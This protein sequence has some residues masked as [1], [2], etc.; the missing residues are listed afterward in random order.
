[1][2]LPDVLRATWFCV[3]LFTGPTAAQTNTGEI[4]GTI[5][6]ES[7]GVLPGATVVV[8]HPSSGF[9]VERVSDANGRFFI[10]SLP[11][12]EWEVEVELAGF[13]RAIQ[14]GVVLQIGRTLDLVFDLALG[15]LSEEVT[16][17]ASA[18]TLQTTTAE[19][20]DEIGRAHV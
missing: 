3:F 8:T 1:M 6:D 19:I 15:Q 11:I 14:R 20:S 5:R 4:G 16:V 18:P 13:S 10:S 17:A 9:S 12:G 2:R 7:G